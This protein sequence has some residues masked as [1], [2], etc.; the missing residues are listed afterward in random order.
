MGHNETPARNA[1]PWKEF[2]GFL[3]VVLAAYIGYLGVHSQ[4]VIPIQATQTAEARLTKGVS[5]D[6]VIIFQDMFDNTEGSYDPNFWY[7]EQECNIESL[8]LKNGVLNLHRD[9]GGYT[10]LFLAKKWVTDSVVS[11]SGDML[12]SNDS[13]Y[14]TGWLHLEGSA[15]CD[16]NAQFD[17]HEPYIQC[18]FGEYDDEA[19]RHEYDTEQQPISYDTWHNIMVRFDKHSNQFSFY[20]DGQNIGEF[21]SPYESI[22]TPVGIGIWV[23]DAE[24]VTDGFQAR[25]RVLIDNVV[26]RVEK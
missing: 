7:C 17:N 23:E 14:S 15:G 18:Y 24:H 6:T 26:L 16:I 13:K 5:E 19:G 12:I 10:S 2:L 20:L 9:S 25:G 22:V 8:F 4:I 1:F 3:G 21:T 11:L